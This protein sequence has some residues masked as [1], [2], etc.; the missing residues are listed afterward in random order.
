[1]PHSVSCPAH[2][3]GPC[4]VHIMFALALAPTSCCR[5]RRMGSCGGDMHS[6]TVKVVSCRQGPDP[7]LLSGVIS[8]SVAGLAAGACLW[9][10]A[11]YRTLFWL[12]LAVCLAGSGGGDCP[13][14]F[15]SAVCAKCTLCGHTLPQLRQCGC[16]VKRGAGGLAAG[17]IGAV[18][19]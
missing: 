14:L 17:A 3:G 1:M 7:L 4:M 13:Q 11:R 16:C 9:R 12:H 5:R 18:G 2:A 6:W 19:E 10:F 15:R 8:V